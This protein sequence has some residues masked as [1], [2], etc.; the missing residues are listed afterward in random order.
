MRMC[1]AVTLLLILNGCA[2]GPAGEAVCDGTAA[3]R[4][5]LAAALVADGGP[6]S[7]EAGRTLIARLDA[8]CGGP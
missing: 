3:A 1:R 5:A 8:G 2:T 6:Q 4:S 7:R